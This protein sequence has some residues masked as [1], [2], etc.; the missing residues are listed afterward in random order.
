M[1]LQGDLPELDSFI[2][3]NLVE[4]FVIKKIMKNSEYERNLKMHCLGEDKSYTVSA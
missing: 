1:Q 3:K 4:I 2:T